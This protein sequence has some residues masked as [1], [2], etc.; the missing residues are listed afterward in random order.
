METKKENFNI[1]VVAFDKSEYMLTINAPNKPLALVF[2]EY[3]TTDQINAIIKD[4]AKTWGGPTCTLIA[5]RRL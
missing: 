3:L 5:A 2:C 4:P 1:T